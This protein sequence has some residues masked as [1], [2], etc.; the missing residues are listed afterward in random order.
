MGSTDVSSESFKVSNSLALIHFFCQIDELMSRA[1]QIAEQYR[2]NS[3]IRIRCENEKK[4]RRQIED[5]LE[6]TK[7]IIEQVQNRCFSLSRRKFD[8]FIEHLG[9]IET[10]TK[11]KKLRDFSR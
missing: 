3:L 9:S 4:L 5:E 7:Q 6:K 10:F 11:V 8:V 1:E 2:E